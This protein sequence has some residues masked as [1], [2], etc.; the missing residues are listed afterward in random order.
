MSLNQRECAT[1]PGSG[2]ALAVVK[3]EAVGEQGAPKA[4][5]QPK[6]PRRFAI[7]VDHETQDGESSPGKILLPEAKPLKEW[8]LR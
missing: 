1:A 4:D 3:G 7:S 2:D 6:P 5:W 8:L